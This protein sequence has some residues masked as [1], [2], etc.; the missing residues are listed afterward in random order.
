MRLAEVGVVDANA[1]M[2]SAAALAPQAARDLRAEAVALRRLGPAK[3]AV[4]NVE[5][6]ANAFE[7]TAVNMPLAALAWG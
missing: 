7:V 5:R 6:L 1:A 3:C 2:A 4:D